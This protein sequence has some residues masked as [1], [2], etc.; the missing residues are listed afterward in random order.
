VTEYANKTDGFLKSIFKYSVSTWINFVIGFVAVIITTRVFTPEVYGIINIFNVTSTTIMSLTVLGLDSSYIRFYNE[1]P[2]KD[3]IKHLSFKLIII[4]ASITVIIGFLV[5]FIFYEPFSKMIF[6]KSSWFLSIMLFI[7]VLSRLIFR[8]L[9]IS[10]RM[11]FNVKQYTIQSVLFQLATKLF[12]VFAALVNPTAE[13]AIMFNVLGIF[14]L[15][16]LYFFV[17]RK[18]IIPSKIDFC[19]TGYKPVFKFAIFSAPLF[20]TINLKNFITQQIISSYI[21]ISA[22]GIYSSASYFATILTVF[23][24]G[25]STYW[26]AFMFANYKKEEKRII[27]IHDYFI[28]LLLVLFIVIAASKDFIYL[29]IGM[30]YHD[31]KEFFA[32]VLVYPIL[33]MASETT[34]YGLSIAKKNHITFANHIIAVSSNIL[35][36]LLLIRPFG[37]MGA[38]IASCLSGLILFLLNTY[39]GQRY[40][41]SIKNIKKT[42]FGVTMIVFVS[43]STSFIEHSLSFLIVL[44]FILIL[45]SIIYH[46]E[47][48]SMLKYLINLKTIKRFTR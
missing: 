17:Q 7:S 34:M 36:A 19:Y 23:Q 15:T 25:F 35:I 32:L 9:N 37:L 30:Q 46:K 39:W 48:N 12:I 44:L 22:V 6:N 3:S 21:S 18:N 24:G 42:I 41:K 31:S 28:Y 27:E 38:A 29:L 43:I 2:E 1:P 40:Y 47:I 33:S 16:L 26:S 8:F 14:F 13:V 4:A 10:Y 20:L 11:S 5:T 45:D